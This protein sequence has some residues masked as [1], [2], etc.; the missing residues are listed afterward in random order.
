[1]KWS[2]FKCLPLTCV[3]LSYSSL[4]L[5]LKLLITVQVFKESEE[6]CVD[7]NMEGVVRADDKGPHQVS[8]SDEITNQSV[9]E[10]HRDETDFTDTATEAT[11]QIE[12]VR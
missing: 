8:A 5:T 4:F 3:F 12:E 9:L 7:K 6:D 1:M 10:S 2:E 11:A